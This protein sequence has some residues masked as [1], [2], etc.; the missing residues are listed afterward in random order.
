MRATI[1][2]IAG[3]TGSGKTTFARAIARALPEGL[4]TIV[5]I[6]SYYRDRPE[7][8]YDE[9]CQLNYDHPD[10]LEFEL[11]V[12]H[13]VGLREA[14]G[15]EM[16]AYDFTTHRRRPETKRVE[17]CPVVVVEGILALVPRELRELFDVRLFVD[18]DA[19]IRVMRR[20]RRDMEHRGRSFDSIREQYYRTVAPMH[21]EL[22]EP[23]KRHADLIL[24]EGGNKEVALSFVVAKLLL[25][26]GG[27]FD[28]SG[29]FDASGAFDTG[30]A[31]PRGPFESSA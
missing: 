13:L 29:A 26:A 14:R 27:P 6:D 11:L 15:F 7:L 21:R 23:S 17:P 31:S 2:G 4:A 5:E 22:V 25:L 19:D 1:V 30:D 10:S 12:S 18:T 16:P 20:I 9:R 8:S 24:P 28:K 3:G